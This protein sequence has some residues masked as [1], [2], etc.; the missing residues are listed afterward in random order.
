MNDIW[1]FFIGIG[2]GLQNALGTANILPVLLIGILIGLFQPKGDNLGIKALLVL[3]V[4]VLLPSLWPTLH[5]GAPVWPDLRHLSVIA[6]IIV[7]Y[8]LA[9]GIIGSLAALRSLMAGGK[10][11]AAH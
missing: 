8:V 4:A 3:L 10:K 1:H 11:A 5:G 7:L 6:Q 2:D 9:Y